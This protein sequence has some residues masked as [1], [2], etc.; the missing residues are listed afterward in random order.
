MIIKNSCFYG[1]SGFPP[2][3]NWTQPFFVQGCVQFSNGG[4]SENIDTYTITFTNGDTSTFTVT[5]GAKGEKGDK[6]D[7]GDQGIQ[8]PKGDKGDDGQSAYVHIKY[9]DKNP[10]S[11]SDM[12]TTA[13][14][15][16]GIYSGNSSTAPTNYSSYTW[17]CI[18]GENSTYETYTVSFD[19]VKESNK[20]LFENVVE[21]PKEIR[22]TQW[23]TGL[24]K[25][26]DAYKDAFKGWFISGTDTQIKEYNF[27]G[28]SCTLE[29]RIE[30]GLY[31]NGELV[32]SWEN[33]VA[34]YPEA[35]PDGG[36]KIAANN[37]SSSYLTS[38]SGDL[39]I[40]NS[41]TEIGNY[42]FGNCTGFTSIIIPSS[43]NTIGASA[44]VFC[45]GLEKIEVA[46]G[47]P[48]Y[49]S[50]GNCLVDNDSN[51]VI[52]GCKNS[53]SPDGVT[54]IGSY[55]FYHCDGLSITINGN[56][57]TIGDSAYFQATN[58]SI[59][60]NGS[61]KNVG[62]RL[63]GVAP[64]ESNSIAISGDVTNIGDGAFH[65]TGLTSI[66]I[67]DKAT[68]I[69]SSAFSGCKSLT[70]ITIP[71]SVTSIGRSAFRNCTN[72]R[73]VTFKTN[74]ELTTIEEV[75][76]GDC[77]SLAQITIP[78]SVTDIKAS[79]FSGCSSL[80]SITLSSSLKNIGNKAFEYCYSLF[81]VIN[82]ST[83]IT[84]GN[85]DNNGYVGRYAKAIING[86][87][88]SY[89]SKLI[90]RNNG[91]VYYIDGNQYAAVKYLGDA[92]QV[93]IE[94]GCK[95]INEGT[96]YDCSSLVS[97]TIPS[98]VTSIGSYAFDGCTGLTSI[99]IPSSV[100]SINSFA[101]LGCYSLSEVVNKSTAFTVN[102]GGTNNGYLGY[103]AKKVWNGAE[104][105]S[106]QTKLVTRD[107][108]MVYYIDGDQYIAVKYVGSE[109][110]V[111]IESG[112]K[113]INRYA[114]YYCENLTSLTIPNGV[115]SIGDYA[116]CHCVNLASITLPS[117][118]QTIG[119]YAFY[120][121]TSLTSITL[122]SNL[123][124]I[125]RSAF[126][127]CSSLTSITI[128]E[129]VTSIE[130]STFNSCSGLQSITIP[131]SV[132]SIGSGAFRYCPSVMRIYYKGTASQWEGISIRS[133]AIESGASI[134]FYSAN[135]NGSWR[136]V[137][138]VPVPW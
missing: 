116:F 88:N 10:T 92:A 91:M 101:F 72:L 41:V 102:V 138:N 26:K 61:V 60:I 44:F 66:T 68:S 29:A 99:T 94:S 21:A 25:I 52:L 6:G 5:N 73:T 15:W 22:S 126:W 28:E 114:F 49:C 31:Q 32:Q 125:G 108:G 100:T 119:G 80:T 42:S 105:D 23:I 134:Y 132:I 77:N 13:G 2:I 63:F 30:F 43:V 76:F 93:T 50:S 120:Y 136:Y 64:E 75:L 7:K 112:C 20:L 115:T 53:V 97:I 133:L 34:Q 74:S 104:A 87:S 127:D 86:A 96:F 1:E 109:S 124:S 58:A 69:G 98:S 107:N 40:D 47:N 17:Y 14:S 81:E 19:Y 18:K 4:S 12:K 106:Y 103:Y 84:V 45:D 70:S 118:L 79:A 62:M 129:G 3:E 113:E 9:A 67:N 38:L 90:T 33:L 27:I 117:S 122:P 37:K 35:F 48:K 89:Q 55:A 111:T 57:T 24:P 8:G 82:K 54:N 65:S 85:N 16:I 51:T 11:N 137:N 128:P 39:I 131:T 36:T 83:Y 110:Q 135:P 130:D 71:S 46:D 59:A 121:C 95:E 123:T 78:A 56:V